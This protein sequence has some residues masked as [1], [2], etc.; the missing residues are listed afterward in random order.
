VWISWSCVVP[1]VHAVVSTP[2]NLLLPVLWIVGSLVQTASTLQLF[3]AGHVCCMSELFVFSCVIFWVLTPCVMLCILQDNRC[4]AL[5]SLWRRSRARFG[6]R[7]PRANQRAHHS[8]LRRWSREH[9][10]LT[11]LKTMQRGD[12]PSYYA[13]WPPLLSF[14][15]QKCVLLW[16]K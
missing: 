10:P 15:P 14:D 1:S 2:S 12:Y 8:L 3:R 16:S 6:S 5:N 7:P 4:R 9:P 11:T 13:T